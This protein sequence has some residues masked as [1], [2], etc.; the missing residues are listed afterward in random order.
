MDNLDSS[1]KKRALTGLKTAIEKNEVDR[2]IVGLDFYGIYLKNSSGYQELS[3]YYMLNAFYDL[4]SENPNL[5]VSKILH[6]GILTSLQTKSIEF[7]YYIIIVIDNILNNQ[8]KGIAPFNVDCSDLIEEIKNSLV[9]N[10]DIFNSQT[11]YDRCYNMIEYQNNK[12]AKE[13]GTS[14]L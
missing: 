4:K 10:K 8:K 9:K 5:D 12:F 14:F 2:F 1:Y 6:D 13:Y 11:D 7:L 3:V